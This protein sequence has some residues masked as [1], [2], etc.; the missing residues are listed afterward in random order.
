VAALLEVEGGPGIDR[1]ADPPLEGG[2]L[3]CSASVLKVGM[4]GAVPGRRGDS[5][6][7]APA[8]GCDDP[9]GHGRDLSRANGK[10][11]AT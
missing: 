10:G 2:G 11:P 5:G 4:V 1:I 9:P 8:L 3:Q 6:A 7:L